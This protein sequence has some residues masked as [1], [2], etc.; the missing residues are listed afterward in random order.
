MKLHDA[1]RTIT[2][3]ET[4]TEEQARS[5]MNDIMGGEASSLQIAALLGA[6]RMRGETVTEII[7][8]ARALRDNMIPVHASST[9]LVDTCGTGGDS[10][11][12]VST[13]NVSTAAAFI[14]AGAGATIAKHGIG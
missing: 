1:L 5:T 8:F 11:L 7:G 9:H 13:F 14:A 3:G 12:G 2:A 4:L 6:L 10:R